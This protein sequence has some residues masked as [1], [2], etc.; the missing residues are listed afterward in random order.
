MRV[1]RTGELYF[2]RV[3]GIPVLGFETRH[4]AADADGI[5]QN[6]VKFEAGR[7]LTREVRRT[8][9]SCG[10]GEFIGAIRSIERLVRVAS[11][12]CSLLE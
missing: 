6:R 12:L 2:R 3:E 7:L 4:G 10:D 11:V 1:G 5:W 9:K 8:R